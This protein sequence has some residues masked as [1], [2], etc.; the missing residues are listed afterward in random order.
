MTP[1]SG[2]SSTVIMRIMEE[3]VISNE[4]KEEEEEA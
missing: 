3:G 1:L 4:D 2:T